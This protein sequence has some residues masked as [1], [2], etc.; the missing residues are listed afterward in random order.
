MRVQIQKRIKNNK[1]IF[2]I[3]TVRNPLNLLPRYFL[4]HVFSLYRHIK[5]EAWLAKS[6]L[7]KSIFFIYTFTFQ[8]VRL[9]REEC[10]KR[11][12]WQIRPGP[13]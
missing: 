8:N 7:R 2:F 12:I 13:Y 3:A 6:L 5:R 9:N 10:M 4:G 1:T 11:K